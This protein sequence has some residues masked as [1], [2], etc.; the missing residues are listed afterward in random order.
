MRRKTILAA[1]ML[2]GAAVAQVVEPTQPRTSPGTIAQPDSCESLK[3]GDR[4]R[5]LV[6]APHPDDETIGAAGLIQRVIE[7]GGTVRVVLVTAGD[8]YVEVVTHETH[9]PKPSRA[10]FVAFGQRRIKESQAA[11]RELDQQGIRLQLLGFPDGGLDALL[12]THWFPG[13]PYRSP[14]TGATDP[15]YDREAL[16]P[17]IPYNG[18]DLRRQLA[19]VIEDARPTLVALPDPLDNHPDHHAAGVFGLL[20][21]NDWLSRRGIA[22]EPRI[23]A[24]LVHWPHWP[25]GAEDARQPFTLPEDFPAHGLG[26]VSLGISDRELRNKHAAMARYMSQQMVMSGMVAFV[27]KAELFIQF[28]TEDVRDAVSQVPRR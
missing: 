22:R 26:P 12:S 4:E 21:L 6:I 14:T 16:D 5:L 20:A 11:M 10:D 9:K 8:A 25:P 2:A 1:L 27:R 23:F 15:P 24:Y 17:C 13:D 3:V 19:G 7:R 18:E 28:G